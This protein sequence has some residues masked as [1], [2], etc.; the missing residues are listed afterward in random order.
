MPKHLNPAAIAKPA[1]RYSQAVEVP[2]NARLLYIAG[3]V[4]VTPDGTT[5]EG[6][7][8]Q[9]DQAW[10]NLIAVLEAAG[11]GASDLVRVNYYLT[12]AAN[13]ALARTVRDRYIKDPPPAATLAI[14]SALASPAW[15]F[16]VEAVAAKA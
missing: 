15:L 3:Q 11:M 14:I 16:E 8:A 2:P 7:A 6:F 5:L 13:V 12:D 9:A 1:G 4:G 10:R